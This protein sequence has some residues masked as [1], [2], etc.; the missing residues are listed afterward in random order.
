M[1]YNIHLVLT[2]VQGGYSVT[3]GEVVLNDLEDGTC[4]VT[5]NYWDGTSAS[6][7]DDDIYS[8][9][10]DTYNNVVSIYFN[11]EGPMP[12]VTGIGTR[13][14]ANSDELSEEFMAFNDNNE[15]KAFWSDYGYGTIT[16]GADLEITWLDIEI[17]W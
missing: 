3:W 10:G 14:L 1:K 12:R 6:F 16:L 17:D 5:L 2:G 15:G 11:A 4:Y 13:S 9:S 7:I 8:L